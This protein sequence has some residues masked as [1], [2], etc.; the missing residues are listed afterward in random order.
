MYKGI[1]R[2]ISKHVTTLKIAHWVDVAF[3]I[4]YITGNK[5]AV[6]LNFGVSKR[7]DAKAIIN[8]ITKP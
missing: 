1:Y 2:S 6:G 7:Y 8:A 4:A 5:Q 3:K